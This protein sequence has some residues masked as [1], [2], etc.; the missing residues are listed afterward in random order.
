MPI[1]KLLLM[2]LTFLMYQILTIMVHYAG[3]PQVNLCFNVYNNDQYGFYIDTNT[4]HRLNTNVTDVSVHPDVSNTIFWSCH[5]HYHV[6]IVVLT[7][8]WQIIFQCY[9]LWTS[10]NFWILLIYFKWYLFM[11][12]G[13]TVL[14]SSTCTRIMLVTY[15][16]IHVVIRT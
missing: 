2:K 9:V 16:F 7:L 15:F 5:C 8:H 4:Y 6:T 11:T 10:L 14:D 3:H 12:L 13:V 1:H